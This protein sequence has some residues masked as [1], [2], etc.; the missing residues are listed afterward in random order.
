MTVM[1]TTTEEYKMTEIGPL[2]EDWKMAKLGDICQHR[3][4]AVEP[5][6]EGLKYVGLEHIDSREPKIRRYGSDREVRSTKNRFYPGDILYGKLRPYLDKAAVAEFDGISST[7]IMVIKTIPGRADG[8]YLVHL[9][10]L[11]E[12]VSFATS[13]MTGVNHP[14]TSW[15]ALSDFKVALPPPPEQK[16][17]AAVLSAVQNAKEKTEAVIKAT[18][19]LKKS[20]MKHLFTYGPVPLE[21]AGNV[22]LKETEIG[23]VPQ[24]WEVVRLGDIA[25]KLLG[26][27]TPSTS[28]SEYW[29]GEIHWTTSKRITNGIRLMDG[30]KRI[31][32]RGLKESSTHLIPRGN[33][34]IGTRVGVGKVAINEVDMAISQDL[35][36]VFIDNKK[37]VPEFLAYQISTDRVQSVFIQCARGT[38]IKGIP[39][40]ELVKMVLAIPSCATQHKIADIVSAV[41]RKIEVEE[42]KKKALEELFK[43]LLSNLMTGK[44]RVNQLEVGA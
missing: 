23:P 14:R 12:F 9:M 8:N 35:T 1:A 15:K 34:I 29:G 16:K 25:D 11:P 17:V 33:L 42:S 7:D 27:G 44:V 5:T 30:E 22:P 43:T 28:K 39:R 31:T 19:E 26:G 37:Y 40:D 18:K 10:H 36:G 24:G 2:P 21:E 3:K 38:T 6:G 41:D 20:L 13:T 32:N 4:E